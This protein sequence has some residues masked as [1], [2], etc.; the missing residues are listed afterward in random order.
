MILAR[1]ISL[2]GSEIGIGVSLAAAL[3]SNGER[4]E[5]ASKA[6]GASDGEREK[7]FFDRTLSHVRRRALVQIARQLHFLRHEHEL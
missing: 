4:R 1:A 6:K 3:G 2:P 7:R 5:G